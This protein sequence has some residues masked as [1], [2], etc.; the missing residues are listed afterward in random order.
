MQKNIV[1]TAKDAGTFTTLIATINRAGLETTLAGEGPFTVFAPI[2]RQHLISGGGG[3]TPR[4]T[5]SDR[6]AISSPQPTE[7]AG[8]VWWWQSQAAQQGRTSPDS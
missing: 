5:W 2:D 3:R 6:R 1:E 7:S 8:G 4:H